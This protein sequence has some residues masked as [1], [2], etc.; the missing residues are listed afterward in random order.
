M[1]WK[2]IDTAPKDGQKILAWDPSLFGVCIAEW[3]YG[4]WLVDKGSQNG[5]GYQNMPISHWMPLPGAPK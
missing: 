5:G 1:E 4:S 3:W 2:T